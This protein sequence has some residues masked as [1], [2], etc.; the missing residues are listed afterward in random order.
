[1]QENIEAREAS[2]ASQGRRRIGPDG[3]HHAG[4]CHGVELEGE[5]AR[6][7]VYLVGNLKHRF[8][9]YAL[10]ANAAIDLL[11]SCFSAVSD[12]GDG[13]NMLR[14]EAFFVAINAKIPVYILEVQLRDYIQF[15]VVVVRVLN[16]LMKKT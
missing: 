14:K 10:L 8:E 5:V 11:R 6:G 9:S 2:A 1:M 13:Q 15:I 3:S 4:I 16:Q 12:L 7:N